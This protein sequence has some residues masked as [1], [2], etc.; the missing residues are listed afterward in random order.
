MRA[1]SALEETL[2]SVGVTCEQVRTEELED[3]IVEAAIEPAVATA[4]E[5]LGCSLEDT[6]ITVDPTP[7]EVWSAHTGITPVGFAIAEYGSLYLP[8]TA[9]GAEFLR[10]FVRHHIAVVRESAIID[11]IDEAF[12]RLGTDI[13]AQRTSGIFAT[14]PSATADMGELVRGAHGPETVHVI[15]VED[16]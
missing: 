7:A 9:D 8:H 13:P 5:D 14:G 3:A 10:L 1:V 15:V 16:R 11:D 12:E 2:R 6:S 4:M